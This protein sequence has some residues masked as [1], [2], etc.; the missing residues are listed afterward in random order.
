MYSLA[1]T[2]PLHL[3]RRV[4][5]GGL[6][7][8]FLALDQETPRLLIS[9]AIQRTYH[10]RK[11]FT[12]AVLCANRELELAATKP[13]YTLGMSKAADVDSTRKPNSPSLN[14]Q[15]SLKIKHTA[16][17]TRPSTVARCK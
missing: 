4:G 17:P 3:L 1:G 14:S 16:T 8:A 6:H 12:F 11:S 2:W 13:T 7:L 5:L 10:I 9:C 15:Y